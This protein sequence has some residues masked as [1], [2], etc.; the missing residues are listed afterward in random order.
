MKIK[1]LSTVLGLMMSLA[2]F[3]AQ[4]ERN[5][6]FQDK[7]SSIQT[8]GGKYGADSVKCITELSLYQEAFKQWKNSN[9]KSA[10]IKDMMPH[11]RWVFL[12]CPLASENTYLNGLK[13]IDH[14]LS[15]AKTDAEKNAY[16][17]TLEMIHEGRIKYFPN[18]YRSGQ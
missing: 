17:D 15:L 4:S 14:Y 13:I 6:N 1:V 12:N 3:G 10:I 2:V 18:H 16:L 5:V 11:W 7:L 9:Y 8:Q